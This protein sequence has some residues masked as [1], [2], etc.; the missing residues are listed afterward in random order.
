[1]AFLLL[2]RWKL[3]WSFASSLKACRNRLT[4]SLSIFWP[5][6]S[7]VAAASYKKSSCAVLKTLPKTGEE[8]S[9]GIRQKSD[10]YEP[11]WR[12]EAE[13]NDHH[14]EG[15]RPCIP[16]AWARS[17]VLSSD[18]FSSQPDLLNPGEKYFSKFSLLKHYIFKKFLLLFQYFSP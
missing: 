13:Y 17:S 2:F 15:Q 12:E 6:K 3:S 14:P 5:A 7:C 9:V 1:M 16:V 11:Q 10:R 18:S 4:A 8:T